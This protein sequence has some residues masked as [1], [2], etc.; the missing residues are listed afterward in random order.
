MIIGKRA[1]WQGVNYEVSI[2][3]C[4]SQGPTVKRGIPEFRMH[5]LDEI[6]SLQ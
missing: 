6:I 1:T 3:V 4:S 5:F 2:N